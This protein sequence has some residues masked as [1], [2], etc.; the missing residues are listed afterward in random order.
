MRVWLTENHEP[1]LTIS[2]TALVGQTLTA[3]IDEPDGLP[4]DDQITYQWI[5]VDGM[6]ETDISGATDSTYTLVD[7]DEDKTIKWR[8]ATPT[9]PTSRSR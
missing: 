6:T 8:R 4:A 5:R 2:G 9:T 3:V 7:A 1:T